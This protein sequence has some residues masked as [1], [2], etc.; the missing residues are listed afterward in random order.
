M[1]ATVVN[2]AAI[3]VGAILGW[4]A[5]I[6]LSEKMS[7][8]L[9]T[10]MAIVVLALGIEMMLQGGDY[11]LQVIISLVIG[12]LVGD[13]LDIEGFVERIG[14][15]LQQ[16]AGSRLQGDLARGFVN[17]TLVYCI[18]P[19]AIIG[20]MEAG[21]NGNYEILLAKAAID[22][23]TAIAFASTQGLGVLFSGGAVLIYQGLLTLG[24]KYLADVLALA[25]PQL[26]ATGGI[27]LMALGIKMLEIKPVSV[28]NLLPALPVVALLALIF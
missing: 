6:L 1:I 15:R 21:L 16:T 2:A 19:M 5:G 7:R 9:V 4:K 14:A 12:A 23:V 26:T 8:T 24:A 3:A 10:V 25:G 17:A 22:G 28:A 27:L 20:A 13:L 11:F 18:G